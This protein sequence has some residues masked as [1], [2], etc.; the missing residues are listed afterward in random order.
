M[1]S[2]RQ[3]DWAVWASGGAGRR[4]RHDQRLLRPRGEPGQVWRNRDGKIAKGPVRAS[5]SP[6]NAHVLRPL[7]PLQRQ[8]EAAAA[9]CHTCEHPHCAGCLTQPSSSRP[10]SASILLIAA[11]RGAGHRAVRAQHR[12]RPPHRRDRRRR[13]RQDRLR[14]VPRHA[15]LT[16]PGP[17]ARRSPGRPAAPGRPEGAA[18]AE[19]S[20]L[21]LEGVSGDKTASRRSMDGLDGPGG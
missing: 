1:W 11:T 21:G 8:P 4:G 7:A 6:C 17:P 9:H 15:H 3:T 20:G 12:H 13:L 14:G 10:P 19:I 2:K 5:D 18:G 16:P